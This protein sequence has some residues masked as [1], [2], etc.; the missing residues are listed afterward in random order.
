MFHEGNILTI[1]FV[2]FFCEFQRKKYKK[3]EGRMNLLRF[4][5]WSKGFLI[6]RILQTFVRNF[7]KFYEILWIFF[8]LT[9]LDSSHIVKNSMRPKPSKP[10]TL[11]QF[12]P[13]SF[14]CVF[15][16]TFFKLITILNLC[17]ANNDVMNSFTL[18]F[19]E[20]N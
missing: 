11:S 16:R 8:S 10:K 17:L 13:L 20:S 2:Q 19:H 9:D 15:H 14:F 7:I 4:L 12:L 5:F 1:L 18:S 6:I 3:N